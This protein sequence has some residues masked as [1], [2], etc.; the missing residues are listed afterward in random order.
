MT[1]SKS[2]STNAA[3]LLAFLEFQEPYGKQPLVNKSSNSA[4]FMVAHNAA[5]VSVM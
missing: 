1:T 3:Q 2:L 5:N 4:R